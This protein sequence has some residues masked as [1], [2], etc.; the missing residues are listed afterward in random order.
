MKG[1]V[2]SVWTVTV[3]KSV[4]KRLGKMPKYVTAALMVLLKD[5]ELNGPYRH[6]WPNYG[7]LGKTSFHCH[8]RK[9]KPTYVACWEIVDKSAKL[10]EVYYA[11]S[12]EKAPY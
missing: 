6:A 8:I 11:G 5:I 3:H 4:V 10:T 1:V 12:H 2:G 7:K 9:G